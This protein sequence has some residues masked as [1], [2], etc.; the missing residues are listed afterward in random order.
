M[1]GLSRFWKMWQITPAADGQGYRHSDLPLAQSFLQTFSSHPSFFDSANT[2]RPPFNPFS[3]DA[4]S[5]SATALS[6]RLF[7]HFLSPIASIDER[8]RA[9]LCLRCY[10]SDPILYTCKKIAHLFGSAQFSYRDLLP[11]VLND[12]GQT[13]VVLQDGEPVTAEAQ[14]RLTYPFFSIKILQS[15]EPNAPTSMSLE[16]WAYFKTKQNPE[17]K[18]FLT[19]FGFQHLSD[20]ALLNRIRKNQLER[21]NESDRQLVAAFH[22][23]YRRDRRQQERQRTKCPVPSPPQLSEMASVVDRL[24]SPDQILSA[25]QQIATQLRQYDV[26][27]SREPLE[28]YDP[29]TAAYQPRSDLVSESVDEWALERGELQTFLVE[30]FQVS[31]N[32]AI[33]KSVGDRLTALSQSRTYAAF[34]SQLIPGLQLYYGQG[35]SLKDIAPRLKMTSWDQARRILNPGELLSRVRALTVQQVLHKTLEKATQMGLT[36]DP[37]TA[38]YLKNLVEQI[39]AFA[40]AEIFQR[41]A[42]ELRAGKSRTMT[43]LYAQHLR[44]HL[45]HLTHPLPR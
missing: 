37:P 6:V 13:G 28:V 25:L 31:L 23:V 39:E 32:Q 36:R 8:A 43:S 14:E 35:L 18:A 12:D 26:W 21:L 41:A 9:G 2:D 10:V 45:Q 34:A 15:F 29:D 3:F 42:E 5:T 38:D 11:L 7:T 16:N 17:I 4:S 27:S 30:E 24:L 22:S 1:I 19:E 33:A 20:W 44:S 40:D